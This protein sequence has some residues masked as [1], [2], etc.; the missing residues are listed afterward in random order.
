M[1]QIKL[2]GINCE[3]DVSISEDLKVGD[4]IETTDKDGYYIE[5]F[6]G[7]IDN[8]ENGNLIVFSNDGFYYSTLSS[9]SYRLNNS[10]IKVLSK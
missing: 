4:S 2:L 7:K 1:K 5:R 10:H 3:Y 8:I 9:G 6:C